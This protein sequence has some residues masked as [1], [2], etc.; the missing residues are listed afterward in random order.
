MSM[1]RKFKMENS[2]G[3]KYIQMVKYL[4]LAKHQKESTCRYRKFKME[5]FFGLKYVQSVNS[6][7][8]SG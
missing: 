6:G 5:D 3:Q 4:L 1:F 8:R 2:F 7:L